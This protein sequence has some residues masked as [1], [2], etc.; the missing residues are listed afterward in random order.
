MRLVT[1]L[2]LSQL[3]ISLTSSYGTDNK[4]KN[5][6]HSIALRLVS[7][8]LFLFRTKAVTF[9]FENFV[10]INSSII[11]CTCTRIQ[12]N[13]FERHDNVE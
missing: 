1:F 8:E 4:V 5:D 6:K 13:N 12:R 2:R 3:P 10:A 11:Q 9:I 7:N